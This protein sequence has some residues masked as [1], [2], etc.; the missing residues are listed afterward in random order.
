MRKLFIYGG[1][2][3]KGGG[4]GLLYS[5]TKLKRSSRGLAAFK[6]ELF[7]LAA[8]GFVAGKVLRCPFH[9]LASPLSPSFGCHPP[10]LSCLTRSARKVLLSPIRKK[11]QKGSIDRPTNKLR[12][13][14]LSRVV[15][16]G[17]T[18]PSFFFLGRHAT[19]CAGR[20]FDSVRLLF[21]V[22][23]DSLVCSPFS[24]LRY[25]MPTCT[26]NPHPRWLIC[27]FPFLPHL[28][29][30]FVFCFRNEGC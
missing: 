2:G 14:R 22:Y 23:C 26:Q 28:F 3:R 21:M 18:Q 12:K 4:G 24:Q 25:R 11:R 9:F 7:F 10:P 13:K 27:C 20:I 1:R 5:C 16:K 6:K 8:P 19:E 15:S 30:R 29:L 17:E